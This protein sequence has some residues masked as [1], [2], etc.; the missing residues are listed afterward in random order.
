MDP[1]ETIGVLAHP[2]GVL[3]DRPELTVG[4][5]R[6]TS[7]PTGL[8]IELLARRPPDERSADQRQADIR[9]RRDAPP[10]A[11]RH[12]LPA[13]DEG[14]DLRFGLLDEAGHA[15]WTYSSGSI[16]DSG[17]PAFGGRG[18]ALRVLFRLQP[19]F[20]AASFVLAWPEIGFPETVVHL[21][22]PDRATVERDTVSIWAAPLPAAAAVGAGLQHRDDRA[23]WTAEVEVETG[24]AVAPPGLL[25]RNEHA[26]VLLTRLTAV[27]SMLSMEVRSAARGAVADSISETG[28]PPAEQ[29]S[30]RRRLGA[31]IAL[32]D[33]AEA[34]WLW[35]VQGTATGGADSFED[36]SEYVFRRP[37]GDSLDLVTGWP[38]AGLPEARLTIPLAEPA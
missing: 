14:L 7:H 5:V 11:E 24:R 29:S 16:S 12:L 6:A 18:P 33:S 31:S 10:I 4:V 20:D 23:E 15:H 2:G 35:P 19:L 25:R 37:P 9:G 21:T 38:D 30:G 22:L 27:G 17:G 3:V 8:D 32:L 34:R 1:A 36:T 26:A 28:F 13:Y